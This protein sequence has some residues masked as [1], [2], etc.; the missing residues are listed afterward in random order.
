MVASLYHFKTFFSVC[1]VAWSMTDWILK[2][3]LGT[4]NTLVMLHPQKQ[5]VLH[6][7]A[8]VCDAYVDPESDKQDKERAICHV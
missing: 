4:I 8:D 2:C 3:N 6:C 7:S 1:M 5:H